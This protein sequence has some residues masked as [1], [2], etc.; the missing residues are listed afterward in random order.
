MQLEENLEL[1]I[2]D[3]QPGKTRAMTHVNEPA[4]KTAFLDGDLVEEK[5][6]IVMAQC[7]EEQ[8]SSERTFEGAR[9]RGFGRQN[10][11]QN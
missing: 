3:F 7:F 9:I 8:S 6:T 10:Q 1:E 11:N 4:E 2:G 5:G